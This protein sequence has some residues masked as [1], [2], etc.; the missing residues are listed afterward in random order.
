MF[1]LPLFAEK[2]CKNQ[3]KK[4]GEFFMITTI[5]KRDGRLANFDINKIANAI[6]KAFSSTIGKKIIKFV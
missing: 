6:Q 4:E 2:Y 1:L 3:R 5:Q